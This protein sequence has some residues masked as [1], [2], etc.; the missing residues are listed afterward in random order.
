[1]DGSRLGPGG[2]LDIG[3]EALYPLGWQCQESNSTV[4]LYHPSQ[5]KPKRLLVYLPDAGYVQ[6]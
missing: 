5:G 4:T 1:M 3:I 6:N 2:L